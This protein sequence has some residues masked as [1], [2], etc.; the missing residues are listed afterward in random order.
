MTISTA[1]LHNEDDIRRKDIREGDVVV[2]KRAG[3]V[4]PQVVGAVREKRTGQ[5]REFTYPDRCPVCQK[6][7][8]RKAGEARA[9]CANPK[10]PAQ[11]LEALKHF[12]SQGAM[13]VRGLGGTDFG[14]ARCSGFD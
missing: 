5:E 3:D 9:Y 2:V 11:V 10:C 4:I 7:V 12:V 6:P 13:D 8:V 1:T 14:K